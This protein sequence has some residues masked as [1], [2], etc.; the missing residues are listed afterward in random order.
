MPRLHQAIVGEDCLNFLCELQ[1]VAV[2]DFADAENGCLRAFRWQQ[3]CAEYTI[4]IYLEVAQ[5][6]GQV[7]CDRI[8]RQWRALH[9]LGARVAGDDQESIVCKRIRVRGSNHVIETRVNATG[10]FLCSTPVLMKCFPLE[11]AVCLPNQDRGRHSKRQENQYQQVSQPAFVE[12]FNK[13]LGQHYLA[14]CHQAIA[15]TTDCDELCRLLGID[16]NFAT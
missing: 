14:L 4:R 16:F 12:A 9:K 7:S 6:A 5:H 1:A 13:G 2:F 15:G 8:G 10:Q 11:L 3:R